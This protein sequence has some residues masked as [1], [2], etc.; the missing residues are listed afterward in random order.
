MKFRIQARLCLTIY[1][2]EPRIVLSFSRY[3]T[4]GMRKI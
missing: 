4:T 1:D 2:F 3:Q